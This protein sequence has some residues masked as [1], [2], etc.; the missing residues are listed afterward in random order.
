MSEM[1][2]SMSGF[3]QIIFVVACLSSAVFLIKAVLMMFGI[4]A[5]D[6]DVPE[7]PD[8]AT[9][10]V[11]AEIDADGLHF[12]SLHGIMAFFAVGSW[13]T[14]FSFS[15]SESHVLALI[16]GVVAGA[17]MMVACAYI[18][19]AMMKLQQSG[20]VDNTKAVGK[21][22]EVYLRIPPMGEGKGK[23]NVVLGGKE[24]ECEAISQDKTEIP[25]G[26]RVR[27]VDIQDDDVM[28]VQRESEELE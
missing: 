2:A 23:I 7:I 19:R 25:Y 5:D 8:D 6:V 3:E 12:F 20:N 13:A 1:F 11:P 10:D 15:K 16:I 18:M 27:V 4:G 14:L 28:V 26:T 22:G 9:P 21:I 24:C 17:L